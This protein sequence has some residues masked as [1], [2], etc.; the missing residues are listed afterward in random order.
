M[1]ADTLL[2][3]CHSQWQL[4]ESHCIIVWL[5]LC[6]ASFPLWWPIS[7]QVSSDPSQLSVCDMVARGWEEFLSNS[8]PVLS[9]LCIYYTKMKIFFFH[10]IKFVV[11]LLI[12]WKQGITSFLG[13]AVYHLLADCLISVSK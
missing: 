11:F 6:T 10:G 2:E 5:F 7:G 3:A 4:Q 12:L 9:S 8:S 13:V 1:H